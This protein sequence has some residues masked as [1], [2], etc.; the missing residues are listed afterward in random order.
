MGPGPG[1][2]ASRPEPLRSCVAC[3]RA[4]PQAE[5]VRLVRGPGGRVLVDPRGKEPGR[6]AYLCRD[7]TC[8]DQAQ[9]KRALDRALAVPVSADDW[10]E[11]KKGMLRESP[12][13]MIPT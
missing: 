13:G 11:L 1:P 3:R 10:T 9:R 2:N 8:W 7:R 6:G 5:L 4:R 12:H